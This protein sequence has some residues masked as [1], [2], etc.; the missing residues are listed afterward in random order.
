MPV[1]ARKLGATLWEINEV[2]RDEEVD[3]DSDEEVLMKSQKDTRMLA[4]GQLVGRFSDPS[5]SPIAEVGNF[6]PII[7]DIWIISISFY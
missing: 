3:G 4:F 2:V 7:V 6:L 5:Q 1:S